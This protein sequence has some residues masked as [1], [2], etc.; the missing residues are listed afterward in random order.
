MTSFSLQPLHKIEARWNCAHLA[1]VSPLRSDWHGAPLNPHIPWRTVPPR[2]WGCWQEP[3]GVAAPRLGGRCIGWGCS[4]ATFLPANTHTH[5]HNRSRSETGW[6]V[7]PRSYATRPLLVLAHSLASKQ[8]NTRTHTHT[9][10]NMLKVPSVLS[11]FG[12]LICQDK[13]CCKSSGGDTTTFK[14]KKA[15]HVGI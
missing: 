14:E 9:A 1:K 4:W 12:F 13:S 6:R 8:T 11:R 5:V 2:A 10:V 7:P 15:I 3:R